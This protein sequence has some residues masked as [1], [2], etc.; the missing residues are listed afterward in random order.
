[1]TFYNEKEQLYLEQD[2]LGV[3]LAASL[4]QVRDGMQFTRNEAPDSVALWPKA[5][6][7]KSITSAG[8]HCSNIEIEFIGIHHGLE[9]FQHYCFTHEVSMMTDH[10]VVVAIFKKDIASLSHRLQRIILHI[11]INTI[12]E[13]STNLGH[14]Y[15]L[16]IG[17]PYTTMRQ[18]GVK[19]CLVSA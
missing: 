3:G 4:L 18:T 13:Y 8:T 11:L 9:N 14:N 2:V 12:Y 17:Y 6:A 7:S 1:M 10:K 5:F 15:S 19:K 16:Q